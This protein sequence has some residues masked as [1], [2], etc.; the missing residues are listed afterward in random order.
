MGIEN[1]EKSFFFLGTGPFSFPGWFDNSII[2]ILNDAGLIGFSF[3][4][5]WIIKELK[6]NYHNKIVYYLILIFV[7]NCISAEFFLVS[8][9]MIPGV[10]GIVLFMKDNS[11]VQVFN[12]YMCIKR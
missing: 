11:Y 9:Y 6:K 4:F 2:R 12:N 7:F 3:L 5:V 1:I 8:R 10:L